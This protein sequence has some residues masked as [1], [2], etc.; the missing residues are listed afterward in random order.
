MRIFAKSSCLVAEGPCWC[1]AE[2]RL[3][4][5]DVTGGE[6]YRQAAD[7]PSDGFERFSPG[8][9]KIGALSLAGEGEF[10]LFTER[11]E[12]HRMR[13]GGT[14]VCLANLPGHE[15]TRFNDVFGAGNGVFFCGVAPVRPDFRGEL[16][17]FDEK[18]GRFDC[19]ESATAGMPNGMGL[20]P[21]RK[22]FY[23]IVTDERRVYAYDFDSSAGTVSNR[24]VLI[25]GFVADGGPDGMC[26]D[27]K[28]GSLLVAFWGGARIERRT[29]DGSL[30]GV[31][32]F[33]MPLVT[34]V[35]TAGER[36]Y[37]TTANYPR[38]ER[39]HAETGAGGVFVLDRSE[40]C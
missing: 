33:P 37:V 19:I 11:C 40:V 29:P 21:D 10:L 23:F 27:P 16:W 1:A 24:R 15:G 14:P 8:L 13:F 28:D 3:Y 9:G 5:V 26:V 18:T 6:V 30:A 38:D 25:D 7:A 34:S 35:T 17:R 36:I 12:I 4:W 20:S 32:V 39:L 31:T 2:R 22:T